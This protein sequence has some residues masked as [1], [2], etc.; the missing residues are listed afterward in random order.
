MNFEN[1]LEPENIIDSKDIMNS[2][3][4]IESDILDL[5]NDFI[6]SPKNLGTHWTGFLRSK[7]FINNKAWHYSAKCTYCDQIF[8]EYKEA[9]ANHIIN[10]CC[11]ISAKNKILYSR[12]IKNKS[13]QVIKSSTHKAVLITDYFDKATILLEKNLYSSYNP[14]SRYTLIHRILQSEYAQILGEMID[15]I[16]EICDLTLSLNR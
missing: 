1:I 7:E 14:P 3:D 8:E 4:I 15:Q 10:S 11:K 16:E 9:I 13:E 6:L 12:I 2:K 5:N